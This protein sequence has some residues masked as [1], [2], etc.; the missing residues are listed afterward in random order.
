MSTL[1]TG[2]LTLADLGKRMDPN[3]R[4]ARII[5]LLAQKNEVLTEMSWKEGNL[6]TG[7]LTTVR[8]GLPTVYWRLLNAGVPTSKSTTA[9]VTEQTGMLEAYSQVDKALAEIGGD[10]NGVRLSEARPFIEAMNQE[11]ASTLFYG[12]AAAAE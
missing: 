8:T 11:L 2:Y 3:D 4:I 9:Q 12:T 1:G 7:E 10:V 6:T 5:E